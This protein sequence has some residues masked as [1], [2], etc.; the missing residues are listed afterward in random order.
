MIASDPLDVFVKG[1][2]A[3]Y[4]LEYFEAVRRHLN[5]GGYFSLYVP[6]YETDEA[7]IR[8]ELQTFFEAFPNA[9][10]WS[11]TREG[12][13][14]DLVFLGQAE[15][16]RI[17]LD[18][19]NAR[20]QRSDYAPVKESLREI[21][22]DS[23]TDLFGTWA[24][25]RSDL[26]VWTRGA[27]V[28]LDANLRLSYLAGWGINAYMQDF[29]YRQMLRYRQPAG[30]RSL[31]ALRS[32]WSELRG[33]DPARVGRRPMSAAV[34]RECAACG[35]PN[36]IPA[37]HLTHAGKCGSCHAPI[38][39]QNVPIEVGSDEEFAGIVAESEVPVL[40]DFWAA[41]CGPCR[42][43]APEV[44]ALA[45]EMAGRALVLKVDTEALPQVASRFRV[46]SIP[47]FVVMKDGNVVLQQPGLTPRAEMKR[48]WL[49]TARRLTGS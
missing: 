4:S 15:P 36:R 9:T 10:V 3:L 12:R 24:G 22:I 2:A 44:K 29:L 47:N 28:N 14:Y 17:N 37:R 13:G 27:Q 26:G 19:L 35:M 7:T 46:Q 1:T 38:G 25:Q 31:P 21:G 43:A 39:P 41:W 33:R 48:R 49:E 42:M 45:A 8:S 23:T 11:N 18:E 16:L 5:P 40:I 6:L 32:V 20:L 34:V 30:A